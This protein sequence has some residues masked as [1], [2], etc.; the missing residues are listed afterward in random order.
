MPTPARAC[1][2]LT[3][4]TPLLLTRHQLGAMNFT[5]NQSDANGKFRL[6][7]LRPGRYAVY[8]L[9]PG[10]TSATYSEPTTFDIAD[11]DVTGIEIKIRHGATINGVAVIE[12]NSDPAV[13]SLLQTLGLYA[14]VEQ[15]GMGAPSYGASQIAADG[16]FHFTGLAPGKIRMGIQGFPAPP[17]GISLIRTE[18]EG[19]ESTRRNCVTCR[20][21]G[22]RRSTCFCLW[23]WIG[24]RSRHH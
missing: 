22:Q 20:R 13:A 12:N 17:K 14:Y 16:S 2:T 1:P 7:G 21:P 19:V 18:L 11:A 6:E 15:K 3:S 10:Q 4:L 8:T 23:D 5:G 9:N 24:S